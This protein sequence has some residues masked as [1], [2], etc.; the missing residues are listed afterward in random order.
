M[1]TV[2]FERELPEI[3]EGVRLA[4]GLRNTGGP[5]AEKPLLF[6]LK[7]AFLT[8]FWFPSMLGSYLF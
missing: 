2:N 8:L 1:E 7:V 4:G 6:C 3:Q 5:D